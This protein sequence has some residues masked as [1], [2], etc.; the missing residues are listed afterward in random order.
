M[1]GV[2]PHQVQWRFSK[3][4]L[5]PNFYRGLLTAD[6]PL[7]ESL[8]SDPP[9]ALSQ[10]VDPA[11]LKTTF[12]RWCADPAGNEADAVKIYTSVVLARWLSNRRCRTAA[13]VS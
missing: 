7:L 8:V 3:A 12:R 9:R 2:L 6:R 5:S 1:Q 10:F 11:E 13:L 4:D